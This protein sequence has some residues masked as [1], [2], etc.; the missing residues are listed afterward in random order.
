MKVHHLYTDEKGDSHFGEMEI[1]YVETTPAGALRHHSGYV[2][3]CCKRGMRPPTAGES[4]LRSRWCSA[5]SARALAQGGQVRWI[6][7]CG[8]GANACAGCLSC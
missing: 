6:G 4:A 1:E 2:C 8:N 5:Q 3:G 7:I